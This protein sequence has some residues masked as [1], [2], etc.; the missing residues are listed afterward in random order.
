[1]GVVD[2]EVDA[3]AVALEE[4]VGAALED[5]FAG[6]ADRTHGTLGCALPFRAAGSSSSTPFSTGAA[7]ATGTAFATRAALATRAVLATR[8]AFAT[9]T[10]LA[11][12]ATRATGAAGT[13]C[14]TFPVRAARSAGSLRV[15]TAV[16][17]NEFG[18]TG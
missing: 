7:L 15:R 8:A 10:A 18:S 16:T 1:M 11:T 9:R 14:T 5:A 2:Q 6:V 3:G 4:L 13:A 17:L 12:R